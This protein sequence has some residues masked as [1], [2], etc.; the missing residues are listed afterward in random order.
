MHG[1]PH[2]G[3]NDTFEGMAVMSSVRSLCLSASVASLA[4]Q[5]DGP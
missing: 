5:P 2:R 3:L 1:D 4:F